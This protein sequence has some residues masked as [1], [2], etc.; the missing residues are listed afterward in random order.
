MNATELIQILAALPPDTEIS[1]HDNRE[2]DS[3]LDISGV[4]I[5]A[6]WRA[7]LVS[8]DCSGEFSKAGGIEPFVTAKELERMDVLGEEVAGEEVPSDQ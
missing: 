6:D 4:V 8:G 1:M 7:L 3:T 5:L 2:A